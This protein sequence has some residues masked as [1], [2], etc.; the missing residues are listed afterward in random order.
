ML[1]RRHLFQV[2][3]QVRGTFSP[4]RRYLMCR[5]GITLISHQAASRTDSRE[6]SRASAHHSANQT[7]HTR[8]PWLLRIIAAVA[9]I[10]QQ[11]YLGIIAF[12]ETM[13][14]VSHHDLHDKQ[15]QIS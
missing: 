4:N 11:L 9:D 2:L 8:R 7:L 10:H 13:H 5:S 1:F 12:S 14:L 3:H 15:Q 6:A